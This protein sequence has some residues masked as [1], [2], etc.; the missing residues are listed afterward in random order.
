MIIPVEQAVKI[1]VDY[2]DEH[3]QPEGF[4]SKV[5][6]KGLLRRQTYGDMYVQIYNWWQFF[7]D[8]DPNMYSV[9]GKFVELGIMSDSD[10][11]RAAHLLPDSGIEIALKAMDE[12]FYRQSMLNGDSEMLDILDI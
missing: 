3:N 9:L 11:Y 6:K 12:L 2:I 1:I 7:D 10:A 4:L 5:C 8:Q